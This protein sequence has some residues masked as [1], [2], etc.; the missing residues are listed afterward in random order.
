MKAEV[1]APEPRTKIQLDI[2]CDFEIEIPAEDAPAFRSL[3]RA[4]IDALGDD[5]DDLKAI[6]IGKSILGEIS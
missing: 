6:E 2:V 4:G 1:G 5:P 3:L